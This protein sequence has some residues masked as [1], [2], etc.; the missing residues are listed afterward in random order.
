MKRILLGLF[1]LFTC[2]CLLIAQGGMMPGPGTAHSTGGS[3]V[4]FVAVSPSSSGQ[5]VALAG[6]NQ[7]ITWSDTCTGTNRLAVVGFGLGASSDTG[8]I[9]VAATYGGVSMTATTL[10]HSNNATTGFVQMFYMINPPSGTNTVS[11]TIAGPTTAA[12]EGGSLCFNGVDQVTGIQHFNSAFGSS[13]TP[14]ATITSA[15]GNMVV[16]FVTNGDVIASSSQTSRYIV[17]NTGGATAAGCC[18]AGATAAGGA[19]VAM[20]WTVTNDNWAVVGMDII[21]HP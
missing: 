8:A 13:T 16:A 6:G 9:P 20:G 11:L 5:K 10:V 15:T 3:V 14:S 21:A 18:N 2:A 17:N 12:L 19:S 4:T 7:N 1:L